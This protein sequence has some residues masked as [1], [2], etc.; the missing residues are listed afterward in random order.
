MRCWKV[1]I[2]SGVIVDDLK[3]FSRRNDS[4]L[5]DKVDMNT[6]VRAALRLM[7]NALRKATNHFKVDYAIGLPAFR[8]NGHRIEQVV[9]NL[10]LNACQALTSKDQAIHL[11]TYALPH[12]WNGGAGST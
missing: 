6:V 11:R 1:Q 8:G 9:V 2:A 5:D 7:D 4:A 10:V 3:E 12:Y